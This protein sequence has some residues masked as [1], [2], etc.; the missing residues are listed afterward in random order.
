MLVVDCDPQANATSGLGIDPTVQPK[1]MYDAFMSIFEGF[2]D[3]SLE[4]TIIPTA[5]GIDLAPSSL[6]LVGVEPYLYNLDDRTS[7]LKELIAG[8]RDKYDLILIDTPPSMGQFV[9]NGLIAAD[10]TIVTLD[11]GI[12]ALR[13]I[14]ALGTIFDD[15]EEN[16][17]QEIVADMAILTRWGASVPQPSAIDS[18]AAFLKRLFGESATPAKDE[19]D[20]RRLASIEEEV[21]KLF[22]EVYTVP[23]DRHIYEAQQQG[24]PI[25]H[26]APASEAALVYRTIAAIVATW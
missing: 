19:L 5:S 24:M 14:E 4:D 26:Y 9:I 15:I 16:I 11:S 6:D 12:F 20:A 18:F 13:G 1:N 3:V 10:R 22:K 23:Y 7:I 21:R 17:G 8:V 25:S 2:P